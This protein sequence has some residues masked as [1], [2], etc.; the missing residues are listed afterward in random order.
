M[1]KPKNKPAAKLISLPDATFRRVGGVERL[2]DAQ[3]SC[4]ICQKEVA[5]R[6]FA[7]GYVPEKCACE[8]EQEARELQQKQRMIAWQSGE[9]RRKAQCANCYTWLDPSMPGREDQTFNSFNAQVQTSGFFA[10]YTLAEKIIAGEVAG[11]LILWSL[12]PGTGKTH[13]AAAICNKLLDATI[14]CLFTSGQNLFHAFGQRFEKDCGIEDLIDKAGRT[15]LLVLDDLDKIYDSD[16]KR[17][18][19]HCIL[20]LRYSRRLPTVITVNS[21]VTEVDMT[22]LWDYIGAF[23]CSRLK[24]PGL[25]IVRMEGA[26]CRDRAL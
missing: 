2:E 8:H 26:D 21:E 22:A 14:P 9:A 23:A 16:F 17:S 5:P 20:D 1:P 18:S 11:N 7:N 13:L 6:Q 15:P 25:Q 3:R 24:E 19:L 12:S 4:P 10:A